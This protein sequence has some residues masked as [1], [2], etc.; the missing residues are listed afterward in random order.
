[1]YRVISRN[2]KDICTQ[3]STGII[4]ETASNIQ[5]RQNRQ[6]IYFAEP[7]V[8]TNK[9]N[10]RKRP[11]TKGIPLN[12]SL[13]IFNIFFSAFARVPSQN[14]QQTL[15]TY[16]RNYLPLPQKYPN[17][18]IQLVHIKKKPASHRN[19]RATK[20]RVIITRDK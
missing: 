2:N 1:M 16:P 13:G 4:R 18:S 6:S 8:Y 10:I 17:D 5:T 14:F 20:N 9:L 11:Y 3:K 7:L 12:T 19:I 15:S